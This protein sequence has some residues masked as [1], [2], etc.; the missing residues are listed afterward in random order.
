MAGN[1]LKQGKAPGGVQ[2]WIVWAW[3]IAVVLSGAYTAWWFML[4]REIEQRAASALEGRASWA[5]LAVT[6]W[7]YRLTVTATSLSAPLPGGGQLSA[8]RLAV[9]TTPFNLRLWV[10]DRG[11]GMRVR[12]GDG[13][14]RRV[15]ARLLA[16]SVRVRG[17]G[18]LERFS[19]QAGGLSA[20][21]NGP[22]DRGWDL[23][24]GELHLVHDPRN[25]ERFAFMADLKQLRLT[26]ALAGP[27]AILGDTITHARVAGPLSEAE[28]LI[29]SV[30]RWQAAGGRFQLM[31]GELL[32]GPLSFSELTGTIG[33]DAQGRAEGEIAGV[34]ALRPEGVQVDALSAPVSARLRGGSLEV[35][36][37][38]IG[39]VPALR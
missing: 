20:A 3:I 31:A 22:D 23:D 36:G 11:E 15:E 28:A 35:F 30:E 32:W 24:R 27:G 38:S 37:L 16:G 33:L 7:P 8:D 21:A 25:P 12:I 39:L 6:G 10:F 5:E 17:D 2:G 1:M 4:A 13:P 19:V 14:A 34:G 9:T 29:Q 26:Q 18:G